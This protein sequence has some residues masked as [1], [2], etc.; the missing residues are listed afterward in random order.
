MRY[1]VLAAIAAISTASTAN[2]AVIYSQNFDDAGFRGPFRF[3]D[4]TDRFGPS[5]LYQAANFDGWTF[6]N[7]PSGAVPFN[8]I[9]VNKANPSDGALWIQ[10]YGA[11][12][13]YTLTGLEAGRR[14]SLSTLLSGDNVVGNTFGY[15][16]AVDGNTVFSGSGV[17]Q[18]SGS[19]PFGTT[20]LGSFTAAG[21][22]AVMRFSDTTLN[23]GASAVFDNITIS[24]VP[25]PST[26]MLM[27]AGFGLVGM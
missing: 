22:T 1:L 24:A 12:A 19:N 20:L 7:G 15:Q 18:V 16:V 8:I 23:G 25:D 11:S 21:S 2:S 17:T 9:A 3:D 26:W 5:L 10:E 14:Y 4:R 27:I 6:T 13:S